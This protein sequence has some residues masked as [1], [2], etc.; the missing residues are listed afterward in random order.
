MKQN[1]QGFSGLMEIMTKLRGPGGCAWDKEQT[2]ESL[3][4]Y[5]REESFEVI[6]AILLKDDDLLCEELGDLI[7]QVVF[8]SLVAKDR[9]AFDINN[10]L[11]HINKKLLVRHPH[12]FDENHVQKESL[13]DQWETIKNREKN[14]KIKK[15]RFEEI[16]P[17]MDQWLQA[18]RIQLLASKDKFDWDNSDE[19]LDKI[20]E[21]CGELKHAVKEGS[22]KHIKEELGDILF[23]AINLCRFFNTN[24]SELISNANQ[25]FMKRYD[26]MV[27]LA[28][29]DNPDTKFKHLPLEKKEMYWKK[30]SELIKKNQAG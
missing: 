8:H 11:E 23:S 19:I 5:L 20:S 30:A 15:T 7:L 18:E 13:D 26:L 4:K 2:H 22:P 3:I 10:V 29:Q 27:D 21:E 28:K 6:E 14:K 24:P 25:K 16:P 17:S 1:F 12:V 9:G